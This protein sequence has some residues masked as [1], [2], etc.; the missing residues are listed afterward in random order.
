MV[1]KQIDTLFVRIEPSKAWHDVINIEFVIY[2]MMFWFH[3][4]LSLFHEVYFKSIL[5]CIFCIVRDLAT[6]GL[7]QNILSH[8][9][10]ANRWFVHNRFM[11]LGNPL[12]VVV[13]SILDL[14]NGNNTNFLKI[15]LLGLKY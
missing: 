10:L 7:A 13:V 8:G 4:Y 11:G 3:F 6:L 12:E 1:A 5:V 9:F 14:S 2:L 15:D